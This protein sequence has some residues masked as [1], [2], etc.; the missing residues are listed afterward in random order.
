M[1]KQL[2]TFLFAVAFVVSAVPA[3]TAS[4]AIR[5]AVPPWPGAMVKTEVASQILEAIGYET[6]T[7]SMD[8]G[9]A[10]K[11]LGDGKI[12]VFMSAWL[13]TQEMLLQPLLK[14]KTIRIAGVNVQS[15]HTGLCVPGYVNAE[16]VKSIA[17]LAPNAKKFD[18]TIYTT[19]PTS[20]MYI[21]VEDLIKKDFEGLGSW[22]QKGERVDKMLDDVIKAFKDKKWI[23]FSCWEPH[24][25]NLTL[26]M[27]YLKA[28]PGSTKLISEST[29]NTLIRTDIKTEYPDA[30]MIL[31]RFNV[32]KLTQGKWTYDVSLKKQTVEETATAWIKG[33]LGV[34]RQWLGNLKGANGERAVDIIETK[35]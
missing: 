31:S 28:M 30:F 21:L 6:S 26:D 12:D 10:Y 16:G 13:P 15:T 11:D 29:I 35:F 9:E 33:N 14:K 27:R 22:N 24:W 18:S 23:V 17:D 7:T 4:A 8:A 3:S 19:E 25:M 20:G 5:F 34:V 2:I 1:Y 32:S